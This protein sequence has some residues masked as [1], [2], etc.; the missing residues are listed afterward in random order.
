MPNVYL[1]NSKQ[2]SHLC[3]DDRGLPEVFKKSG[4][5]IQSL[6]WDEDPLPAEGILIFRAIW[7]Y[8]EKR[9]QLTNFLQQLSNSKLKV[10]NP[11]ETIRWNLDKSYL[12][13]LER[14]GVPIIP[15][16]VI[17]NFSFNE[18]EN[19]PTV[20]KP[21][22]GASGVD[23]Y[24]IRS[25]E[26]NHRASSLLGRD[27]LIQPFIPEI[28][29]EGELSFV[30]FA[31]DFSHAVRKVNNGGD[32]RIQEEHGGR[33][34]AYCATPIEITA[35]QSWLKKVPYDFF[36]ARVDMVRHQGQLFL[37]ELE[38]IEPELYFAHSNG[39]ENL[40]VENL[41]KKFFYREGAI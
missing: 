16:K 30:F 28:Q 2:H 32:F 9:D 6:I 19:Y 29:E 25:D 34:Q 18:I 17:Q 10:L 41:V 37:M 11:V 3:P 23:T 36:Y 21:R 26:E 5:S 38:L 20:L 33:N 8:V 31:D 1:L 12:Q 13:E 35:V 14:L 7:D 40:F 27:I 4:I 22:V 24:L 39:G 15:T